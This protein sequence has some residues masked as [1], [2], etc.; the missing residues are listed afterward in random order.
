MKVIQLIYVLYQICMLSP[1]ALYRLLSSYFRC[2]INLMMLLQFAEKKYAERTVLVDDDEAL[3]YRELL[4]QSTTLAIYLKDHFHL[5]SGQKVGLLCNNHSALVKAIF[6]ISRL[7]AD[8]HLL[9]SEMSSS[10]LQAFINRY[11]YDLLIYDKELAQA[12]AKTT[13]DKNKMFSYHESLPAISNAIRHTA[14][15]D[16]AKLPRTST[17][18]IILQTGGTTGVPKEAAHQPS[19]FH[20]LQPFLA[21]VQ[22]L[23]I[24]NYPTAYIAT[25]IVHG[26]G[27]AWLLLFIPLG[28]KLVIC[29]KFEASKA[30]QLIA[31]HEVEVVSVVPS[32]LQKMLQTNTDSLK[33]LQCMASGGAKLSTKLVEQTF[34][35]LGAVLYNLYGTSESGLNFIA[36]PEDLAYSPATIGKPIRGMQ[37]KILDENRHELSTG[38]IGQLCIR[39][40]WSIDNK[41]TPW[42]PTGDLAYRDESGYYFLCGRTDEMI[43]SGGIN[44]YPIEVEQ[45]L[46]LHPLIEDVAVIGV[47]DETFGQRLKVFILPVKKERVIEQEVINWLRPRVAR[48]QM[49]K[50]IEFVEKLPYTAFG[51]LD[52]KQLK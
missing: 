19:L 48:Y 33:S 52:K 43:V 8:V 11:D 27:I 24:V 2:G 28:K 26:Y 16:L 25:P 35:S 41:A 50:T 46:I 7:G 37:W 13:Y 39:N 36:T 10:Q 49:P 38:K 45:V 44:V 34:Q 4:E 51:K 20:Y 40:D 9:N 3:T 32:M 5:Q 14:T 22:R 6:A 42:I 31:E 23:K 30:C 15:G 1:L 47:T 21:F 12:V 18:K 29:R 17:S